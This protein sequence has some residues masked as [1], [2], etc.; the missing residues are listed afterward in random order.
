MGFF[1]DY[2]ARVEGVL[3]G[4]PSKSLAIELSVS[5]ELQR[6]VLGRIRLP[7]MIAVFNAP[8]WGSSHGKNWMWRAV[9]GAHTT[10]SEEVHLERTL[11]ALDLERWT[12]QMSTCSG[13]E[14]GRGNR[15][16]SI[17]LIAARTPKKFVFIELKIKSDNPLHAIFE[18]LGYA[19]TYLQARAAG[20]KGS[21]QHDVMKAEDIE[22]CDLAPEKF[23]KY[24]TSGSGEAS[25]DFNWLGA[26][27]ATGL[28][29]LPGRKLIFSF[30]CRKFPDVHDASVVD[31]LCRQWWG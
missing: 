12:Y 23:Y 10:E 21:G 15:R 17:D 5:A 19:L 29:Q 11:A 20:R 24:R 6:Q 1:D 3:G 7:E 14:I 18:L 9:P 8:S 27:I 26:A 13:V 28:N 31:T 22:L 25:F 30:T 2:N 4:R 16:R